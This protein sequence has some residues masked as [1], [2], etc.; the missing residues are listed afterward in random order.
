MFKK[1]SKIILFFTEDH[2]Y[3]NTPILINSLAMIWDK[4]PWGLELVTI[5]LRLLGIPDKYASL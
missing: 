2:N 3:K 4:G 1:L 5:F